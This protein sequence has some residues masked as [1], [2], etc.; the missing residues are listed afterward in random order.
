MKNQENPLRVL[1]VTPEV[2]FV[3]QVRGSASRS[4]SARAGGL[5]ISVPPMSM[6]F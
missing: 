1:V 3:P 2:T 6:R 4:V 5:G